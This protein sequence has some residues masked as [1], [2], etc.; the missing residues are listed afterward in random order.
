MR[1]FGLGQSIHPRV[2][3]NCTVFVRRH[4]PHP[5]YVAPACRLPAAVVTRFQGAWVLANTR[6]PQDP[7]VRDTF[8]TPHDG[9]VPE[10]DIGK[11]L[12]YPTRLTGW[13][14]TIR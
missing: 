1:N 10:E 8:L 11:A 9:P 6:H 12:G 7:L 2:F 13:Y 14:F 4:G 5:T 3:V